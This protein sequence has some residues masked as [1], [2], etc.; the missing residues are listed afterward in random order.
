MVR[1]FG[2]DAFITEF[3]KGYPQGDEDLQQVRPIVLACS[4]VS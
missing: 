1:R 4:P 3:F 2:S